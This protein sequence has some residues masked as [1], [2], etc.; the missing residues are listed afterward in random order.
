MLVA[1]ECVVLVIPEALMLC[2]H[3]LETDE[4]LQYPYNTFLLSEPVQVSLLPFDK[5]LQLEVLYN[6]IYIIK[7]GREDPTYELLVCLTK[8]AE[9]MNRKKLNI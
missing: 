4:V 2:M 6:I 7:T 9:Q 1:L 5:C 3:F 8:R